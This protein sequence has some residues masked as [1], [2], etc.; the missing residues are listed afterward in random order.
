MISFSTI[1]SAALLC[2]GTLSMWQEFSEISS[3][4]VAEGEGSPVWQ[5]VLS[6]PAVHELPASKRVCSHLLRQKM[7]KKENPTKML[8]AKFEGG[9][10][11]KARTHFTLQRASLAGKKGWKQTF[12]AQKLTTAEEPLL[13]QLHPLFPFHLP[14]WISLHVFPMLPCHE[15]TANVDTIPVCET[16]LWKKK[17]VSF[18]YLE[19]FFFFL[20]QNCAE[21]KLQ[22]WKNYATHKK[23]MKQATVILKHDISTIVCIIQMVFT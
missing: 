18:L 6:N 19:H 21:S 8:R 17:S 7:E 2:L 22:H 14:S 16:S 12:K 4:R 13:C 3:F 1:L 23:Q 10:M 9:Y 20:T 11:Q 15:K 5:I